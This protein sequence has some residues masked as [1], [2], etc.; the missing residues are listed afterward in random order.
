MTHIGTFEV[1]APTGRVVES[2]G[3]DAATLDG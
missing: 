3:V 2:A 1:L